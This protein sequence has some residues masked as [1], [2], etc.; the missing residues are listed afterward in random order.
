MHR[1]EHFLQLSVTDAL[2]VSADEGIKL[3]EDSAAANKLTGCF[4]A[5]ALTVTGTRGIFQKAF[6][7]R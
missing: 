5:P 1:Y 2:G 6:R 3:S 4:I 7:V